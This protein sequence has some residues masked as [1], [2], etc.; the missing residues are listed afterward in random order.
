MEYQQISRKELHN[1]VLAN[2]EDDA[3]FYAYVDLL[4]C[5]GKLRLNLASSL[6][7]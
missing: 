6:T 2:R 7:K 1:Y 5:V 3:A 4:H